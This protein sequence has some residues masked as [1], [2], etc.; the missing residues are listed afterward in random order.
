MAALPA[1][2]QQNGV[3]GVQGQFSSAVFCKPEQHH[4]VNGLQGQSSSA[5]FCKPEQHHGVLAV[6]GQFSVAVLC[7]PKQHHGV[8]AVQ[9]QLLVLP[10]A[11]RSWSAESRRRAV[12]AASAC[13]SGAFAPAVAISWPVVR[14]SMQMA[15]IL[16][17][18]AML[19]YT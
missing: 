19:V 2:K 15:V 13:T 18:E 4:G 17:A 16:R 11:E 8:M 14:I 12:G 3:M 9:G 7:K 1:P 6:Q 5:V 10:E